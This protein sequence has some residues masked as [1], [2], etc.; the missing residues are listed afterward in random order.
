L[1]QVIAI[2][3]SAALLFFVGRY[4][5]KEKVIQSVNFTIVHLINTFL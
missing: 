2:L 3:L 5:F 4:G 1:I